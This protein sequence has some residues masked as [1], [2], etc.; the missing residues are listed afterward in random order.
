MHFT[1]EISLGVL[2]SAGGIIV[3]IITVA[4]RIGTK[5]GAMETTARAQGESIDRHTRRLDL[6]EERLVQVVGEVQRMIGRLE[7]TQDRIDKRIG[8]RLGEGGRT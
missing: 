1:G 7:A 5:I 3:T 2:L 8:Q 6:Y 4:I